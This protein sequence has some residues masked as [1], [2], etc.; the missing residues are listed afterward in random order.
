[1]AVEEL[2]GNDGIHYVRVTCCA[3]SSHAVWT[4]LVQCESRLAQRGRGWKVTGKQEHIQSFDILQG[5]VTLHNG[6]LCIPGT[7]TS[8]CRKI[9]FSFSSRCHDLTSRTMISL[10]ESS[11]CSTGSFCGSSDGPR[12]F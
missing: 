5:V 6:I 7:V 4:S 9:G 10:L 12:L 11:I 8:L 1:M 2:Y 3:S